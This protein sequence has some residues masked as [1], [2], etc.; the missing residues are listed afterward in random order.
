M[1]NELIS[2]PIIDRLRLPKSILQERK[3]C[4]I[5]YN[6]LH[7]TVVSAVKAVHRALYTKRPFYWF[8]HSQFQLSSFGF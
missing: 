6:Q 1:N 8:I 2:A 5:C 3:R 4:P 7:P